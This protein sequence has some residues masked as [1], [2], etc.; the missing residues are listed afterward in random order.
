MYNDKKNIIKNDDMKNTN[1]QFF[2]KIINKD[3]HIIFSIYDHLEDHEKKLLENQISIP[4]V[5][6]KTIRQFD[7]CKELKIKTGNN[8]LDNIIQGIS[9][10]DQITA[11]DMAVIH[12]I[13]DAKFKSYLEPF[14]KKAL[15]YL[16]GKKEYYNSILFRRYNDFLL[17]S[18]KNGDINLNDMKIRRYDQR[19]ELLSQ[20]IDPSIFENMDKFHQLLILDANFINDD[21]DRYFHNIQYYK[22]YLSHTLMRVYINTMAKDYPLN[23]DQKIEL[24]KNSELNELRD[25][26]TIIH[27][28][29]DYRERIEK[30]YR[31][32]SLL[33][34]EDSKSR[35]EMICQ[36][37]SDGVSLRPSN[38]Y[39]LE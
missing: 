10:L 8:I 4:A 17:A 14:F 37:F 39:L 2:K 26:T 7:I 29:P 11:S 24:I 19:G 21:K 12:I 18:L 30:A 25:K 9:D 36:C 22:L 20:L 1:L 27:L 34:I 32:M 23:H 38:E 3:K 13:D 28:L 15:I 33:K 5:H 31:L 16:V 6:I 35:S